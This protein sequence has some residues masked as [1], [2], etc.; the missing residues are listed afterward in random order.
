VVQTLLVVGADIWETL[1]QNTM[2]PPFVSKVNPDIT[3]YVTKQS[4]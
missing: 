3:D 2:A 1:L 4:A